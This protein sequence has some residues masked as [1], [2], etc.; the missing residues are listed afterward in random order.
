MQL[1]SNIIAADD[2]IVSD[3][4]SQGINSHVFH[5]VLIRFPDVKS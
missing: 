5:Y 1:K 2:L 4:R 3:A